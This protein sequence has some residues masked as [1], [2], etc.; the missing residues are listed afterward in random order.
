MIINDKFRM[1]ASLKE[2]PKNYY[3]RIR[4]MGLA[5]GSVALGCDGNQSD[6]DYIMPHTFPIGKWESYFRYSNT[7]YEDH[8]QEN[9]GLFKSWFGKYEDQEINLI[10]PNS[11]IEYD[12]WVHGHTMSMQLNK[13]VVGHVLLTQKQLRVILFECF[14]ESYRTL[15]SFHEDTEY[16]I[17][18][19]DLVKYMKE[20]PYK[21][22]EALYKVISD[23]V[24]PF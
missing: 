3:R 7:D 6:E 11:Q 9:K 15:A 16:K 5:T 10:I 23:E 24:I 20:L 12:A 21:E 14:K 2:M 4:K 8:G 13:S 18:N 1:F 22:Q 19:T 17:K